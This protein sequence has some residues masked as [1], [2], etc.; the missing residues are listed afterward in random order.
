MG[1]IVY[2]CTT[3]Y[4]NDTCPS[5][6]STCPRCVLPVM[7]GTSARRETLAF[8]NRP[9][10]FRLDAMAAGTCTNRGTKRVVPVYINIYNSRE[11]EIDLAWLDCS[12][13]ALFVVK[14]RRSRLRL[15]GC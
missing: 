8:Q 3:F 14:V 6:K 2:E 15:V 4:K 9:G 7:R 13:P 10:G 12:W 11:D 5:Y 1:T